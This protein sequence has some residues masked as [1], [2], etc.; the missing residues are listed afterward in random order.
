MK[1]ME[2][3]QK[4]LLLALNDKGSVAAIG[5]MRIRAFMVASGILELAAEDIV[6]LS[7]N[8]VTVK[9]DLP[10]NKGYLGSIY[11]MISEDNSIPLKKLARGI[12]TKR[13]LFKELFNAVGDSL[14][15]L[16]LVSKTNTGLLGHSNHFIP[17]EGAKKL[18]VEQIRAELLEEGPVSTDTVVL[19]SLLIGSRILKNYFS[20]FEE[21]DLNDK[22]S[23]LR[24]DT[25]NKEIF[26]M[27]DAISHTITTI[28]AS[29]SAGS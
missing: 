22:L 5:S 25:A 28:I 17:S 19:S 29:A 27:I 24:N 15:E 21:K 2:I 16:D 18:I 8:Q 14:V 7:E 10:S 4:Y 26:A 13:N 20:K 9:Q 1:D 12:V 3:S 23:M 6:S 11:N